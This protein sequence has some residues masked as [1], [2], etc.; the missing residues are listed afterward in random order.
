MNLHKASLRKVNTV[1]QL[2]LHKDSQETVV[3]GQTGTFPEGVVCGGISTT[4]KVLYT[5]VMLQHGSV[6][7]K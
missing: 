2:Q 6:N 4:S 7:H 1:T 3:M 5:V